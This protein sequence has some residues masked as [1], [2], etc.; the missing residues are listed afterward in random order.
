MSLRYHACGQPVVMREKRHGS[1]TAKFYEVSDDAAVPITTCPRCGDH[2]TP[3][4]VTAE[5]PTP[6][7]TLAHWLL[8]WPDLRAVLEER[9]AHIA[10]S[11]PHVYPYHAQQELV[12]FERQLEAVAALA[13]DLV[14]VDVPGPGIAQAG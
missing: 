9:R 3:T 14:A 2:L 6:E 11:D 12:D 10:C 7:R 13:Q 1:Y 5:R 4:I 8:L